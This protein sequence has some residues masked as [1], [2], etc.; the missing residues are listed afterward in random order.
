MSAS[1]GLDSLTALTYSTHAHCHH[2]AGRRRNDK[3]V[4]PR[5]HAL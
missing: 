2:W 5:C 3:Q 1:V 4:L